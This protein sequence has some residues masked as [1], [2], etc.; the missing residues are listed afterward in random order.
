VKWVS[1]TTS[2]VIGLSKQ[3]QGLAQQKLK[4]KQR[5]AKVFGLAKTTINKAIE[6]NLDEKLIEILENFR[7]AEIKPIL[8]IN[9]VVCTNT[10]ESEEENS[11]DDLEHNEPS[12]MHRRKILAVENPVVKH[13]K[14][15]PQ[16]VRRV[17]GNV[18]N[19]QSPVIQKS[20]SVT[21]T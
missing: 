9:N 16:T 1:I 13:R 10:N 14:G 8:N 5:F 2:E 18:E 17:L 11:T 15:R 4:V 7:E 20:R 19:Q 12:D 3:E 6:L 21:Y